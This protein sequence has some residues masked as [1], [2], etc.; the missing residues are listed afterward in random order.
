MAEFLPHKNAPYEGF[1]R[2]ATPRW[3]MV[4]A[5]GD[6]YVVLRD[7][8]GLAVNKTNPAIS[9]DEI[10]PAELP[11]GPGNAT[12]PTDRVFRL[13]G[14][15]SGMTKLR[16]TS[17]GTLVTQLDVSVKDARVDMIS[18]HFVSDSANHHTSRS[19]AAVP[20]WVSTINRIYKLQAN[21][22]V[23]RRNVDLIKVPGD[24]GP[25]IRTVVHR[26]PSRTDA[27]RRVIAQRDPGATF[28]VF[29]VWEVDAVNSPADE[30][31]LA[32]AD[33]LCEDNL[34]GPPGVVLAHEFGHCLGLRDQYDASRRHEL[35]YGYSGVQ[36]T[37]LTKANIEFINGSRAA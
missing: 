11:G 23:R 32:N 28:N 34:G 9:L 33:C 1:D 19:P 37:F 2:F 8:A 5:G 31:A 29:C 17:G 13:H 30:D 35:M 7:G 27:W 16:A 4:P 10:R 25:R 21:I 6:R 14:L 18:F 24:L 26:V 20:E 36:G 22:E 15:H 3:Q 12:M